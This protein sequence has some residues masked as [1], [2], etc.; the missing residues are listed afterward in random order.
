MEIKH[1]MYKKSNY[2]V[3]NHYMVLG[4]EALPKS[5]ELLERG[6]LTFCRDFCVLFESV[7]VLC[8]RIF[9]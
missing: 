5:W 6:I 3:Y 1:I 2:K 7:R 9:Y 4:G 8:H